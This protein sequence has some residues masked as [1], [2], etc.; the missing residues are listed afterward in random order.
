VVQTLEARLCVAGKWNE[1]VAFSHT[2][3]F[4][5]N[6]I[7]DRK[8]VFQDRKIREI[9]EIGEIYFF[10]KLFFY[11]ALHSLQCFCSVPYYCT[12]YLAFLGLSVSSFKS[13]CWEEAALLAST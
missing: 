4:H 1:I 10:R 5:L 11:T 6:R 12:M 13:Y 2:W 7:C 9:R 8:F 3:I